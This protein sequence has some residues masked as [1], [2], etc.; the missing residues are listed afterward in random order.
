MKSC[1]VIGGGV[2]GLSLAYELASRDWNVAL[3]DRQAIGQ[4]ASWAG[5]G[6]LPP[7]NAAT[8]LHPVE[9]LRA[10]SHQLHSEWAERLLAE[11]GIDNGFRRCGGLYL[12][13]SPGEAAAL[14]AMSQSC[15]EEQIACERLSTE[16]LI[17]REPV[18]QHLA[19]STKLRAAYLL[20]AEC[21]LRNPRHLKALRVACQNRGVKIHEHCEVTRGRLAGHSLKAVQTTQGEMWADKYA[22]TSGPWTQRLLVEHGVQTGIFPVR[23]QMVLFRADRSLFRTILNEGPRYLVPRD[24][25]Y[26]LAGSTEEEV[27]FDKQTT[28]QGIEELKAF[29]MSLVPALQHA[30]IERTW[31]GLRPATFDSMPYIGRLPDCENAFVASGHFRS[32]LHLSTGT[33]RVLAELMAGETPQ[34]DLNPFRISRG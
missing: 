4:E 2:I 5:A 24:D 27:G 11:T 15:Q 34:L 9:K 7:A 17:Q 21:Q 12:A 3:L 25:G 18:L 29:S 20:P 1:L 10:L 30:T 14:A 6:I 28:E 26:V 22:F 13:R 32:G 16:S 31:A 8:A 19:C 33:A 23:G